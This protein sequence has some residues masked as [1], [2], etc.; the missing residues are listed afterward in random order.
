[1]PEI[2]VELSAPSCN[3]LFPGPGIQQC[4]KLDPDL[5]S[6]RARDGR[7]QFAKG[8]SGNPRG[9]PPGIANPRRRVPDLVARPLSAQALSDLIARKPYL[10][11]PLAKQLLP[12]PLGTI[13]RAERLGIDPDSLR[14]GEDCERVLSTLLAAIARGEITPAE[15]A[16]IARRVRVKLRAIRRLL[17]LQR[18][19]TQLRRGRRRDARLLSLI[20]RAP[21]TGTE[22]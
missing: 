10:L 9:R 22:R 20:Q 11:R 5:S 1:M 14:T 7:G 15:G 3:H 8:S 12:P 21:G 16:L 17:R 2:A 13:D 18:R 4:Q 19:L 6:L